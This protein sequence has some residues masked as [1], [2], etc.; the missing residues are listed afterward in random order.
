MTRYGSHLFLDQGGDYGSL[1]LVG[2]NPDELDG[3]VALRI[4]APFHH[5]LIF[6]VLTLSKCG[7]PLRH[8]SGKVKIRVLDAYDFKA[9]LFNS[10]GNLEIENLIVH[11]DGSDFTEEDYKTTLHPDA[12]G[13]FF[14]HLTKT[15]S[16]V[17]I[18]NIYARI[19]GPFIQGMMFSEAHKHFNIQIGTGYVDIQIEYEYAFVANTLE[20]SFVN[21]GDNGIKIMEVKPSL[22]NSNKVEYLRYS[23]DQ[24]IDVDFGKEEK[25]MIQG[26]YLI[27]PNRLEMTQDQIDYWNN[28]WPNFKPYEVD[29]RDWSIMLYLPAFDALQRVRTKRGKPM[30]INSAWRTP[31]H[32]KRVGGSKKSDHTLIED[33]EINS[34]AFDLG[35]DSIQEGRELEELL[36]AEGFNAIGRY[37]SSMFIHGS[38]R[39]PKSTGN[40]YSWGRWT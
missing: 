32:N 25:P 33:R 36:I 16:N 30:R 40:I 18:H 22:H 19:T 39:K 34:S 4:N 1:H 38:M 20:N 27:I 23:D 17:K 24:K 7:M 5:E 26:D 13:Q 21:V 31:K 9:D 37:R 12:L 6:D 15:V 29:S 8:E 14:D 28:R 3:D 35:I 2:T 10:C 11:F